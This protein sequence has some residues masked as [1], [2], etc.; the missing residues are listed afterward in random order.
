MFYFW[1]S[2]RNFF[3]KNPVVVNYVVGYNTR[4]TRLHFIGLLPLALP[5]NPLA[6]FS[7]RHKQ[8][9][10]SKQHQKSDQIN[11]LQYFQ[12]AG[13]FIPSGNLKRSC[14][15]KHYFTMSH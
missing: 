4:R 8:I 9:V 1:L 13:P 6:W 10:A 12:P 7:N 11:M 3:Q 2:Y 14:A 15:S 5:I